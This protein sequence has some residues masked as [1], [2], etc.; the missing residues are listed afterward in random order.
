[1]R[2]AFMHV[3]QK[4]DSDDSSPRSVSSRCTFKT[5]TRTSFPLFNPPAIAS[6]PTSTMPSLFA[7][8]VTIAAVA[9]AALAFFVTPVVTAVVL[10]AVG[11]GVAGPVAGSIAAGI[12]A[13]IGNVAAGSLFAG[14]QSV[15]MG[16]ALSGIVT[17]I[18]TAIGGIGAAAAVESYH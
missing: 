10:G 18:G 1:M 6:C 13:G 15:A 2:R 11:F 17:A 7:I 3:A 8:F 9:G 14:A 12:Q 16:G 5:R 4:T